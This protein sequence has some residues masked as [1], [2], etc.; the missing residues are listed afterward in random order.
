MKNIYLIL[1]FLASSLSIFSQKEHFCAVGKQ[2]SSNLKRAS[3]PR[4]VAL[5]NKYDVKF[6]HLSLNVTKDTNYVSGNV[7]TIARVVG[8][9]IDTFVCS[10]NPFFNFVA[11]IAFFFASSAY[12]K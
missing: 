1:L 12:S 2:K 11:V 8:T 3:S 9:P 5:M 10:I 4:A 7:R 6:H